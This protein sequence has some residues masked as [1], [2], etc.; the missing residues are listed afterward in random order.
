MLCQ[1]SGNPAG[2]EGQQHTAPRTPTFQCWG[3]D[4]WGARVGQTGNKNG[5]RVVPNIERMG[6][7]GA[8][9]QL[10]RNVF[11]EF[12]VCGRYSHGQALSHFCFPLT[13]FAGGTSVTLQ[14]TGPSPMTQYGNDKQM[15]RRMKMHGSCNE[16]ALAA[17]TVPQALKGPACKVIVVRLSAYLSSRG[18]APRGCTWRLAPAAK[19]ARAPRERVRRMLLDPSPQAAV[20]WVTTK[21]TNILFSQ[22][23]GD[24]ETGPQNEALACDFPQEAGCGLGLFGK[25]LLWPAFFGA[26]LRLAKARTHF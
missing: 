8:V 20:E 4:Y 11:V 17:T 25:M 13:V 18:G 24:T 15:R 21:K 7:W 3:P 26:F 16:R 12:F 1:A 22:V 5:K 10:L 19:A 2:R 23:K 14:G 6:V 9:P